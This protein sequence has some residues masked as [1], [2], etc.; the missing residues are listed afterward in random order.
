MKMKTTIK[1]MSVVALLFTACAPLGKYVADNNVPDD[2]YGQGVQTNGETNIASLKWQEM[3]TDSE[4]QGLITKALDNNKDL[5]IAFEHVNQAQA[6]LL[7]AKMAY[8][9]NLSIAPQGGFS[10][11]PSTNLWSYD[12]RANF[13]WEIDIF[14]RLANRKK[15]AEAVLEMTEDERQAVRVGL[16]SNVART[17]YNLLMLDDKYSITSEMLNT[18]KESVNAIHLLM[19]EG[20]ADEVAVS[21]YEA[22]YANLQAT[23][24]TLEN[25]I[26]L[27]ENTLSLLLGETCTSHSRS[28]L[29]DQT[30]PNEVS[31]GIPVQMLTF[32]PDVK[33]AQRNVEAAFYT[34]K[35]AW[36][37]FYPTLSLTGG[38]SLTNLVSGAI[39]PISFLGNLGAGLV[40]PVLN[41]GRN[42]ANLKIA[43][44]KQNEARIN[45]DKTLLNA[46]KE[47][48]DA[49]VTLISLRESAQYYEQQVKSLTKARKDTELLMKNSQ[50]KTYLD[51]L[52]AHN[53]LIEASFNRSS[54]KANAL[55]ALVNLY[56]AL[57]GGSEY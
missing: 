55:Q 29:K 1:A 17:Y 35:D 21:Q 23:A 13:S 2:L 54:N 48:N 12:L 5:M 11:S 8:V 36:L 7:G 20:F 50:N 22:T 42:K 57:G 24:A 52:T 6:S 44:S 14:G 27:N 30:L 9:P 3:F 25:E 32:R 49:I 53:A 15:S 41:A 10:T 38:A 39:V 19:R 28:Q 40:A 51:V 43:E 34:T 16:I 33:A 26:R 18:W 31:V 56:T 37:N 4:L 47:V 46:G 45:F